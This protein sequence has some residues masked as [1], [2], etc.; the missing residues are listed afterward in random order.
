MIGVTRIFKT[1][2]RV[3]EWATPHVQEWHRQR[4]LN[5]TEAQRHSQA[6]NWSEAERHFQL[7][8]EEREHSTV[9]R[10]ELLLGLA[11]A[12]RCQSKLEDA[13]RTACDAVKIAVREESEPMHSLALEALANVQL[14]QQRYGEAEKTAREMIR[15]ETARPKPDHAR[16][17]SC[18]RK[19]AS[20]LE[21]SE[22]PVEAIEALQNALSHAEKSFG[23]E[24]AE[25][26]GHLSELGSLHRR[27]GHHGAAQI[28][29][30]RALGIHRALGMKVDGAGAD[31]PDAT[32]ALYNLAASLEESGD[33]NGA[34]AEFERMLTLR[35]RQVGANPEETA[36]VQVRLAV[37]QL[38]TGRVSSARELLINAA[39]RLE[40]KGG[41]GLAQAL[42]ALASAEE[43]SGRD[44]NARQYREKAL[45]AAAIHAASTRK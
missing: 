13:E 14:D 22:R 7:A 23:G 27:H 4:H 38:R 5:R 3:A 36:L 30:R 45:H 25:T 34:A 43:R 1:A 42:E 18:S 20:A 17:A 19:L 37:L 9:D 35:E 10:L 31:S 32:E 16:L 28:C 24:H 26:A 12:Q 29:L 15:L 33:L 44:D 21:R 40:R 11:E 39:S 8:L 2:L 41:P 6:G